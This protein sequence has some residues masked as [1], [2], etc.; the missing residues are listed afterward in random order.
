[1]AAPRTILLGPL[2]AADSVER[3]DSGAWLLILPCTR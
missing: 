1:M 2:V 3:E